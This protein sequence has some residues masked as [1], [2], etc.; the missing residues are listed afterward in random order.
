MKKDLILIGFAGVKCPIRND[1]V[2]NILNLKSLGITI[3]LVTGDNLLISKQNA[4]ESGILDNQEN[5]N[6]VM[7]GQQFM[8][9]IGGLQ[10][11][12]HSGK[13]TL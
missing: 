11:V 5:Q 7:E 12:Q 8:E 2:K 1:T 4:I 10:T 9:R 6:S 13:N 3:R